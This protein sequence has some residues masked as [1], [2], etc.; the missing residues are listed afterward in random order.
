M[1]LGCVRWSGG[2]SAWLSRMLHSATCV[3]CGRISCLVSVGI[4]IGL[5]MVL[6]RAVMSVSISV[7]VVRTELLILVVIVVCVPLVRSVF[8]VVVSISRMISIR[9][10]TCVARATVWAR[11]VVVFVVIVV[12]GWFRAVDVLFCCAPCFL[13]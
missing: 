12:V 9:D 8:I 5:G 11:Y 4:S 13:P 2:I 10:R 7:C 3:R 6:T 1:G